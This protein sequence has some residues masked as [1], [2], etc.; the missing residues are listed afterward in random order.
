LQ[1]SNVLVINQKW[2]QGK[3][4]VITTDVKT[5][6]MGFSMGLRTRKDGFLYIACTETSVPRE[7]RLRKVNVAT[8]NFI[9]QI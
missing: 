9:T 5:L 6:N 3:G 4:S 8:D 1:K 7:T 2:N